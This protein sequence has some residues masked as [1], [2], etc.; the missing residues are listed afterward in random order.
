MQT[1]TQPW[2]LSKEETIKKFETSS[3]GL[4]NKEAQSRLFQYGSN[5]FH[6]K[7]KV[8]VVFLFLRQFI[9]PLI[10]LLIGAAL[11]TGFLREWMNMAVISFAVLLNVLL[12]FYHEYH[13]ENTLDKLK[14]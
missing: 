6:N 10:F 11:I 14:S 12:G 13:A 2:S 3:G 7:E 4:T 1:I 5:V 9:S 8:N